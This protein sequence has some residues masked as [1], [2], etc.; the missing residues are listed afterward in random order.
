M[1]QAHY[2]VTKKESG[3]IAKYSSVIHMQQAQIHVT[4]TS[5]QLME[6]KDY[7]NCTRDFTFCNLLSFVQIHLVRQTKQYDISF[8]SSDRSP[9]KPASSAASLPDRQI[10]PGTEGEGG[11]KKKR[12]ERDPCLTDIKHL[13]QNLD[14]WNVRCISIS[15]WAVSAKTTLLTQKNNNKRSEW[16]TV[17]QY[18][19][20]WKYTARTR[21]TIFTDKE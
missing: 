12:R 21:K 14:K 18:K 2:T 4:R 20:C 8:Y 10:W 16:H 9:C 19:C 17:L 15:I 6:L 13:L 1:S 7:H 11:K 3:L 5:S